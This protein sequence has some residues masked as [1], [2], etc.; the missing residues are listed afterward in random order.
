MKVKE[1]IKKFPTPFYLYDEKALN[2]YKKKHKD[3]SYEVKRF[4]G[5]GEMDPAELWETT[6]N[7]ENRVLKR[8]EIEDAKE[9][10]KVTEMLMGSEVLDRRNF[11]YDHANEAI[12]DW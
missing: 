2:E 11:I 12:L 6:L 1:L 10:S 5:L 8:V 7:P 3:G 4:K 9:A